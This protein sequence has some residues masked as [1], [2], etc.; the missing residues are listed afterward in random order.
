VKNSLAVPS[1]D[2]PDAVCSAPL[3]PGW[4]TELAQSSPETFALA[5]L[6]VPGINDIDGTKFESSVA[7][8][9]LRLL[10]GRPFPHPVR[11]W[12]FL[13]RILEV[14]GEGLNRYMR[15][16][17]GRYRA[18]R[19]IFGDS[20]TFERLIPAASAVGHAGD[21]LVIHALFARTPGSPIANPR[22][23]PPHRYSARFGPLPPCFARA[24]RV[25]HEGRQLLMIGGTAS[26]RGEETVYVGDLASQLAET[27]QNL[28]AL[29]GT[30]FSRDT[31]LSSLARLRV[32][33]VRASDLPEIR[34]TVQNWFASRPPIEYF[35]ADLCRADL[36]VEIEG[37]AQIPSDSRSA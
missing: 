4:A 27:A 5:S 26:V 30:A 29:L 16:N 11:I 3:P 12:N 31:G 10:R 8:A 18:F 14:G 7:D 6:S 25:E 35:Q 22:Q 24:T 1:A 34:T 32:Y 15:F 17:A 21:E 20:T 9:C 23:R 2:P 37:L 13:P 19:A 28:C 33:C 36:M